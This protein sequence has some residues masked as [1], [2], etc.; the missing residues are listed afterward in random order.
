[1]DN[2][3]LYRILGHHGIGINKEISFQASEYHIAQSKIITNKLVDIL[4]NFVATSL[5]CFK[6]NEDANYQTNIEYPLHSMHGRYTNT[7][8]FTVVTP[9]ALSYVRCMIQVALDTVTKMKRL[10]EI[11]TYAL[12]ISALFVMP[13]IK[14]LLCDL[15]TRNFVPAIIKQNK[16]TLY[17]SY[18]INVDAKPT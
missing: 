9:C 3:V 17:A 15:E 6:E 12:S 18:E 13:D 7:I 1:M 5:Q 2:Y 4:L 11:H 8:N 10:Y 16:G 14:S